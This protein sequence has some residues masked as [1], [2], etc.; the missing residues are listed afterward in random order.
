MKIIPDP[1]IPEEFNQDPSRRSFLKKASLGGLSLGMMV[2]APVAEQAAFASQ[3]VNRYSAPSDLEITDLRVAEVTGAPM[4]VPIIRI[5]TNQGISGY[6]EVRDGGSKRYALFLKS[7][8]LGEN[9]CN[10]EKL[11]KK[12]KQL[13]ESSR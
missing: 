10:V 7:R 1:K 6:G 5:D 13:F 12:I 2:H 11:F 8:L 4:R 3:N 9:P